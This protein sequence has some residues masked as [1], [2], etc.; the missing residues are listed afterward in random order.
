MQQMSSLD[1]TY[2]LKDE[3]LKYRGQPVFFEPLHGNNGDR[4]I[5]MGSLELLRKC[6]VRLVKKPEQAQLIVLNGGAGMTDIWLHGFRTLQSY[7]CKFPNIPL[8]IC[9]SSFWFPQT[10]FAALFQARTSPALV[11]AREAYS[12]EIL[13]NLSFPGQIKL[14]LDHDTAFHLEASNYV[15]NLRSKSDRKHILVVERDDPESVTKPISSGLETRSS[16]DSF[17]WR[18]SIPKN[19]KRSIYRHITTPL[20]R[21]TLAQSIGQRDFETPFTQAC[22]QQVWQDYPA[23]Q[24]LPVFAADISNPELC[25]FAMF[26]QLIAEA[27]V[28]VS[29]RLHVGMLGA[30]LDKPTYIKAGSYH[31]I[32]GIYDFSLADRDN[33]RLI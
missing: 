9:P 22:L 8:I 21:I 29:T 3:L 28:V 15:Q 13:Q 30:M 14:A 17:N 27:A 10:D 25:S 33:V 20:K 32:Q 2:P 11:F 26:S 7:N 16:E 4:L 24:H 5:E 23:F 18:N 12:L 31:K 1:F 6:G 19:V